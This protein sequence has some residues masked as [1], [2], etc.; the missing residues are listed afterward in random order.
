MNVQQMWRFIVSGKLHVIVNNTIQTFV[1]VPYV[2]NK[3]EARDGDD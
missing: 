2:T 3:S 1:N